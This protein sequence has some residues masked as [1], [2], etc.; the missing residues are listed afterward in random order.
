MGK[1]LGYNE[2]KDFGAMYRE[3]S[4]QLIDSC[5]FLGQSMILATAV[6]MK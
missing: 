5:S 6:Y 4:A 1:V 2:L 3:E